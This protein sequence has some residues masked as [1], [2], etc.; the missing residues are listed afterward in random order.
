MDYIIYNWGKKLKMDYFKF[1]E[2]SKP[3]CRVFHGLSENHKSL[4][5][6]QQNDLWPV[7]DVQTTN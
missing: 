1:F 2:L 6:D 7:K 4:K 3:S 5:L